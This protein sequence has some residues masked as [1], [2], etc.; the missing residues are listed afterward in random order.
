MHYAHLAIADQARDRLALAGVVFVP[1]RLPPHKPGLPLSDA[2][3][4]A[5]ML[6]LA[7][8]DDPGFRMSDLELRRDGPSYSVD[9]A[10]AL[11]TELGGDPWFILSAEALRGL[12]DWHRPQRLLELVRLAVV[13]RL[14]HETPDAGWL[15]THFPGQHDR[16]TFLDGPM[17]GD[18]ASEIRRLVAQGRSI[19]Y[20]VPPTVERYIRD[21]GL[22]TRAAIRS[23]ALV[24]DTE[25][26][27]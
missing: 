8:A 2:A 11:R 13:P 5:R 18:S 6:E 17:L 4:R 14:R 3:D 16:V 22:Y 23:T 19:R 26:P 12:P 24:P 21:H 10:A 9:T 15:D 27:A 20:L 25:T 7:I 1:A